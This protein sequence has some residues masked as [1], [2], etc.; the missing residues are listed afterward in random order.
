MKTANKNI[1][2]FCVYKIVNEN[3]TIQLQFNYANMTVRYKKIVTRRLANGF[4]K[5]AAKV[6]ERWQKLQYNR[7]FATFIKVDRV[8]H[9]LHEFKRN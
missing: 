5:H 2:D 4:V 9:Y 1:S 8:T 6:S 3:L 7:Q